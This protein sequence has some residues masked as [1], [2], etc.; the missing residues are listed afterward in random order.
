MDIT[1]LK[2]CPFCG[3]DDIGISYRFVDQDE[4][5]PGFCQISCAA[6][7]ASGPVREYNDSGADEEAQRG[8]NSRAYMSDRFRKL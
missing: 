1:H 3:S 6:C 4:V 7:S 2:L 8:W 5:T